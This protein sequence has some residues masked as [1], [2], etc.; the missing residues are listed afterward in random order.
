MIRTVKQAK[1]TIAT[2]ENNTLVEREIIVNANNEKEIKT[3]L[4]KLFGRGSG[5]YMICS[6]VW[7]EKTYEIDDNVFFANAKIVKD[8]FTQ[9]EQA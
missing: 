7:G 5:T 9:T 6:I 2:R 8:T 1:V 3:E 4:N